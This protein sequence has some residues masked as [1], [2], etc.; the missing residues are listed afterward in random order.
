VYVIVEKYGY[1]SMLRE[2]IHPEGSDIVHARSSDEDG[3][4]RE[5]I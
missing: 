5:A 1:L 3:R 4:W 2:D